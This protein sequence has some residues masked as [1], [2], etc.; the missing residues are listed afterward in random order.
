[1]G[2][3]GRRMKGSNPLLSFFLFSLLSFVNF[4]Q[5]FLFL[6]RRSFHHHHLL[7]L[8]TRN[9]RLRTVLLLPSIRYTLRNG[10]FSWPGTLFSRTSPLVGLL[11]F[12]FLFL[13]PRACISS[14]GGPLSLFF[15]PT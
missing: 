12:F 7:P 5:S 4:L 13:L 11:A 2:R 10:C 8:H 1:M 15:T 6:A 3:K 14:G 9:C